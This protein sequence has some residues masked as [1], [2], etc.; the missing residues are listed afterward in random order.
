[1]SDADHLQ[2]LLQDQEGSDSGGFDPEAFPESLL[3]VAPEDQ[4]AFLQLSLVDGVGYRTMCRLIQ[5]F[6]STSAP[7]NEK[8][9]RPI[10]QKT[11]L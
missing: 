3:R 8:V 7:K 6:T 9:M 4:D 1:M 2:L 5:R 11:G 10:I